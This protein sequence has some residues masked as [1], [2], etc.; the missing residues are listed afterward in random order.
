MLGASLF[1]TYSVAMTIYLSSKFEEI[2]NK[3]PSVGHKDLKRALEK[4]R[5]TVKKRLNLYKVFSG[6]GVLLVLVAI[7]LG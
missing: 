2:N 4:D 5:D 7:A 3:I 1:L 6:L